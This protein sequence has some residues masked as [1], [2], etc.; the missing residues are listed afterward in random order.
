MSRNNMPFI[1]ICLIRH[2]F[3]LEH[4]SRFEQKLSTKEQKKKKKKKRDKSE[5]A[6]KF[7]EIIVTM[8]RLFSY[9]NPSQIPCKVFA[10]QYF[11]L[12]T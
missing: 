1:K 8:L 3:E 6:K 10:M 9:K 11:S 5:F 12:N 7:V 4:D 2:T